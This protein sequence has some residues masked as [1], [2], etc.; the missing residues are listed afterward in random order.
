[1]A[2]LQPAAPRQ[3]IFRAPGVVMALIGFLALA[4]LLRVLLPPA[5][6]DGFIDRFA[7]TPA[8]LT[9]SWI[10]VHGWAAALIPFLTHMALHNDWTH[11]T[12]NALWLLA[13][14]PIVARRLG[15]SL[16]LAFFALCGIAGAAAHLL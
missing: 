4:H 15:P 10:A 1:M 12:I 2:F 5:A 8:H 11:F 3:P 6:Q 14:G 13:F 7:F 9:A 16:F